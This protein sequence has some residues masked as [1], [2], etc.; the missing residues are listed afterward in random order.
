MSRRSG[1]IFLVPL[2]GIAAYV[3]LS[4]RDGEWGQWPWVIDLL[5]GSTVLTGPVVA[6]C[7]AHLVVGQ[8][9]LLE[10]TGTTARGWL[11]P[12]RC[13]VQAWQW[14]VVAYL[15]TGV[16]VLAVCLL[17]THGGPFSLWVA[18]IGPAVLAVSALAGALAARLWSDRLIVVVIGPLLFLVGALGTAQVSD[19]LRY[20]PSTGSLAGLELDPIS[21]WVQVARLGA[22]AVLLAAG[23]W[24]REE[25]R[26]RS[27]V[28]LGLAGLLVL[29]LSVGL[30]EVER[31]HRRL[32][33]SAERPTV[34]TDGSPRF[35]VAPSSRR[36]WGGEAAAL[37]RAAAILRSAGV[38]LPARYEES[39]PGYRPPQ[40]V[41]FLD[42]G[43]VPDP[44]QAAAHHLTRPATCPAW[45]GD[46]AP[47]PEETFQA[48]ELLRQWII[49]QSG[50]RVSGWSPASDRWLESPDSPEAVAWVRG[51][52]TLLRSC[53]LDDVRLPYSDPTS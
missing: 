34:C 12:F 35:C 50:H 46:S 45:F 47:P 8:A 27:L 28:A 48:Q 51:T 11:I 32:R 25:V 41:G 33:P 1:A 19:L 20:G 10:L 31:D 18:A 38:D 26:V 21:W 4:F 29:G 30:E 9:R 7:A 39:L 16:I 2:L 42:V 36:S 53:A 23:L 43:S 14:G 5:T 49:A 52:F 40:D 37:G 3:L 22:V 24:C 13:A 17:G 44:L 6:A 15:L